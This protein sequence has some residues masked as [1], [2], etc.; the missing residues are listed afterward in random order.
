MKKTG[1]GWVWAGRLAFMAGLWC[2]AS[3]ASAQPAAG[4]ASFWNESTL[5]RDEFGTPHIEAGSLRAMASAFGYAQAEDHLEPMLMAYRIALGRAAEVGG[6][7]FAESDAFAIKIGNAEQS[8]I[9]LGQADPV[10]RDLC[11]GF[12][13]GINAWILEHQDRVPTWA[14]GVQPKD[15]LAWWHYLMVVQAPF[16]LPGVYHPKA[17]LE[18]ANA[19]ALAPGNTLEGSTLLVMNPHE[20]YGSPY[21]WYEAHL[22]AGSMNLAGATLFGVPVLMMGH[23]ENAGWALT[24]NLADTADFF[25]EHIGGPQKP[26]KDPRFAA[27]VIDDVAPLLSFMSTAKPFYVRTSAGLVE[28]AVPS[29]IGTRG[30]IFEGG[31][32]A[33]YS[34]RNGAFLQFGGLRQLLLMGQATEM[35]AMKDA[36]G[37]HQLPGFQVVCADKSGE[38][39]Y[40]Y[41]A[42]LGNRDAAA[43]PEDRE[44]M[45]WSMPVDSGREI[46]AWREIIAPGLLPQI[47]S[48]KSGY[49][50]ACGTPPWLATAKSGLSAAD[51][52]RWLVAELPNYRTFRVNQ[53]LS[54]GK[55]SFFDMQAMLFDTHVPASADMVPLLLAM[56]GKRPELIRSAHP[57]L[58]TALRLLEGWNLS[59][60]RESPAMAYYSIW[61]TLMKKRHS[62][63]FG[64]EIELYQ[65]L[66][67]NTPEAQV[68]ALDAAVE[69]ARIMRNDFGGLSIPWGNLHRIQRG[70]RNEAAPGT[71]TGDSIF[72]MDNQS[73]LNRQWQASFG[74]GFAMVVQFGEKTQAASIV[75]FGASEVADSPHFGD[76]LNLFLERRMKPTNF[77]YGAVI[78]RASSGYGTRVLLGTPGL[79]G[80]CTVLSA[81]PQEVKL[82]AIETPPGPLPAGLVAFTPAFRPVFAAGATAHTWGLELRVPE[83]ICAAESLSRLQIYVHTLEEG[84]RP[85]PG[86]HFDSALGGFVGQGSGSMIIAV[87]GP[88]EALKQPESPEVPAPGVAAAPAADFLRAPLPVPVMEGESVP[89]MVPDGAVASAEGSVEGI[90]E[91]GGPVAGDPAAAVP[92]PAQKPLFDLEFMDQPGVPQ[93][94]SS[95]FSGQDPDRSGGTADGGDGEKKEKKRKKKDRA[96]EEAAGTAPAAPETEQAPRKA[97]KKVTQDTAPRS[98]APKTNFN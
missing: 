23:N 90:G 3:L 46:F 48:P 7:A 72:Y 51:W 65:G 55:Y 18:R 34:W 30:P 86:H 27:S 36:L 54:A 4:G 69:A 49:V 60:D 41:N 21:R 97:K 42:R 63:Q 26:A 14:E 13:L 84:W 78:G 24:P 6:E 87:L 79:E 98:R 68:Q 88:I 95:L 81:Q 15:V 53:I 91:V 58:V 47:E 85:L 11:E 80:H 73:F 19:W 45:N 40:L 52:P 77:Q 38:L 62:A 64:S 22:M 71:D 59:S 83:D 44:S 25:L 29:M 8:A 37:L 89:E 75:P 20:Y 67:A 31:N 39:F 12:A 74:T 57:D 76:Q 10:T 56:A 17:P 16:D 82:E 50:Q 93:P 94:A 28:R 70:N 61:W 33:L 5:Y 43:S 32:G 66:L 9:A 96:V 2:V 1:T 35:A 92:Q